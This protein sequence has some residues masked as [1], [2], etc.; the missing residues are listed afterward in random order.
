[1]ITT[2][3]GVER[4]LDT[5]MLVIADAQNAGGGRGRDGW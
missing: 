3:D 1:M 2:L 5:E 4:K